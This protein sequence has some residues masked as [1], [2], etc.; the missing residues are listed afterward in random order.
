M[1]KD[2]FFALTLKRLQ[3]LDDVKELLPMSKVLRHFTKAYKPF[4]SKEE[5]KHLAKSPEAL[6]EYARNFRGQIFMN[7]QKVRIICWFLFPTLFKISWLDS[8]QKRLL[9]T[10]I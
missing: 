3:F 7:P 4:V 2:K 9:N 5:A 8:T 6:G 10:L 1:V